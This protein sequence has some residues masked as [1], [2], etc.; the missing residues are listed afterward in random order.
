M[1][2]G[3]KMYER[4]KGNIIGVAFRFSEKYL[5]ILKSLIIFALK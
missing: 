3:T 1:S 5:E 2:F 4:I